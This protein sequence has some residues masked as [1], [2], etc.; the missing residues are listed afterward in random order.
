MRGPQPVEER[1]RSGM[2][3]K[4]MNTVGVDPDGN[5][6]DISKE[7]AVYLWP[8]GTYSAALCRRPKTSPS[9]DIFTRK[10]VQR[11][12]SNPRLMSG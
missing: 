7:I 11:T 8:G 6:L 10:P 2:D 9:T 4:Q 1:P 5:R 3:A 12:H